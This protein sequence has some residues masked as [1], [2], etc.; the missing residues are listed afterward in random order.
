MSERYQKIYAVIFMIMLFGFAGYN[1]WSNWENIV[2][3]VR[4]G[5]DTK[6][7]INDLT[8][9]HDI[10]SLEASVRTVNTA[11]NNNFVG[12]NTW[13]EVYGALNEILGK[14]EE[15]NFAYV[16]DKDGIEYYANFW[17]QPALSMKEA[18]RR[19]KRMKDDLEPKGTKVLVL[20]YPTRYDSEWSN[21]YYGIPY[22]D[23]NEYA[24]EYLRYLRRYGVDYIDYRELFEQTGKSGE[25]IFYKTDHHWHTEAAFFAMTK[26]V[27]YIKYGFGDDLDPTGKYCNIN[28]Y[29][30]DTYK[31]AFMGSMGRE[32]GELYGGRDDYTLLTPKFETSVRYKDISWSG[33]QFES[34]G[35]FNE[36][37]ILKTQFEQ[38]DLYERDLNS[39]YINGVML[40]DEIRNDLAENEKSV[41]MIRNSYSSPLAVFLTP[42]V[43]KMDLLWGINASEEVIMERLENYHYD[44]VIFAFNVDNFDN[45]DNFTF[46]TKATELE[47]SGDEGSEVEDE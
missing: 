17:N 46:Y 7:I 30:R 34:E 33:R 42:M 44:Y 24:D 12:G 28:N 2:T 9:N 32:T 20:L 27:E 5:I 35:T 47:E 39:C 36:T 4:D 22:Q 29:Y 21:G 26:V 14:N 6:V 23:Y 25:E 41:L 19:V 38:D 16:R 10:S 15:N 45:E 37:L 3:E 18:A 43:Q 11:V 8:E 31:D 13:N 40:V 1:I